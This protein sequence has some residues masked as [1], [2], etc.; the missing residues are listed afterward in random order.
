MSI[1]VISIQAAATKM[2]TVFMNL[3]TNALE[4]SD[5]DV[6]FVLRLFYIVSLCRNC[7]A[8]RSEIPEISEI[9]DS[10]SGSITLE[11]IEL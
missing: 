10:S 7:A 8:K 9:T 3:I 6:Q 5:W 2:I 4:Y 11:D 1:N